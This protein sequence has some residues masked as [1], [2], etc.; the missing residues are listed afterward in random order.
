MDADGA[1]PASVGMP[2]V[3]MPRAA[4]KSPSDRPSERQ[5]RLRIPHSGLGTLREPPSDFDSD[6][7]AVARDTLNLAPHLGELELRA[8]CPISMLTCQHGGAVGTPQ[9]VPVHGSGR[10]LLLLGSAA[11][12]VMVKPS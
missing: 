7:D 11:E 2:N 12:A 10:P 6:A 9:Q 4:R 8:R 5:P 1:E 3:G